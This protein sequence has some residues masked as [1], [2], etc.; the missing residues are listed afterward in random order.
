MSLPPLDDPIATTDTSDASDHRC[1]HLSANVNLGQVRKVIAAKKSRSSS[2][3]CS[4]CK[5]TGNLWMCLRCGLVHC[6]RETNNHAQIHH[7]N[8]TKHCLTVGMD[9]LNIWCYLCDEFAVPNS[10]NQILF[11]VRNLL[12]QEKDKQVRKVASK[13][14]LTIS[15][16]KKDKDIKR[17]RSKVPTPGLTNLGNTCFFNSVMQCLAY[18]RELEPYY[19]DP[20]D[21]VVAEKPLTR[22][23]LQLLS[24]M[25]QQLHSGKHNPVIAPQGLFT[26]LKNKYE[27]YKYMVQQDAH[28]LLRTLLGGLKEEQTPRIVESQDEKEIGKPL[29]G[30]GVL[31]GFVD[32]VFQGKLVSIVLCRQ[33]RGVSYRFEEFLDLSVGLQSVLERDGRSVDGNDKKKFNLFAA[34]KRTLSGSGSKRATPSVSR[35]TSRPPTPPPVSAEF[36]E[37]SLNNLT[38]NDVIPCTTPSPSDLAQAKLTEQLF[39]TLDTIRV[40]QGAVAAEELKQQS[41]QPSITLAK[42]FETFLGCDVLEGENGLVCDK[43]N[44]VAENEL[45]NPPTAFTK[46]RGAASA[47]LLALSMN[48]KY[49][50]NNMSSSSLSSSEANIINGDV[51]SI[52]TTGVVS[53]DIEPEEDNDN[54]PS[55]EA[56]SD[57]AIVNYKT[58]GEDD[59]ETRSIIS[60]SSIV[61]DDATFDQAE[62]LYSIPH[63][64]NPN[65][66]PFQIPLE[67]EQEQPATKNKGKK[68]TA[69]IK[70]YLLHSFPKTLVVH[71]KRFERVSKSGSRTRKIDTHVE[72]DE[73][74]DLGMYLSPEE[75]VEKVK[76]TTKSEVEG[77]KDKVEW[78]DLDVPV[79]L[80]DPNNGVYRLYGVVVHAGSLFGGHYVA[81]VRARPGSAVLETLLEGVLS[82]EEKASGEIWVYAS[83]TSVRLSSL[84]EAKKAQAYMLFYE[85][86]DGGF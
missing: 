85:H 21:G 67:D 17:G 73:I 28:E 36:L 57:A 69:G 66:N 61:L 65:P 29:M 47:P 72:F 6:G 19:V 14:I 18:T 62:I 23:F 71:L 46:L 33:C 78:M 60:E 77:E 49:T 40:Q 84:E 4:D 76:K 80:R 41:S 32:A 56:R 8:N 30:P 13:P 82:D 52:G 74:I 16:K 39:R 54:D 37:Q 42:C 25:R 9:S 81:Y 48:Q 3:K 35:P 55:S 26:Q 70:R 68:L 59:Q 58:D 15:S 11:D 75:V 27:I 22:S 63:P 45:E 83:D 34:M 38:I 51:G 50:L 31:C 86:V 1:S 43:C 20:E 2:A 53:V 5:E 7:H 64:N 79:R 24:V 10:K 12:Q 44:G